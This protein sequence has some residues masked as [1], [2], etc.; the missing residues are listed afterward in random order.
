MIVTCEHCGARYKLDDS[1]I[2]GRGAKITCP[3][4]RHLF[5]V[6]RNANDATPDGKSAEASGASPAATSG[7]YPA[8]S[9]SYPAVPPRPSVPQ[10]PVADVPLD[11]HSLDFRRVGIPSWKV[12]VKIGLVYDFSDYRTLR[13]YIQDGRVTPGDHLSYD[14]ETWVPIASIPDLE[15]YFIDVYVKKQADFKPNGRE[16]GDDD[17]PTVIVGA[18]SLASSI[19]AHLGQGPM[20]APAAAG[21]PPSAG[22]T[23]AAFAASV[24]AGSSATVAGGFGGNDGGMQSQSRSGM[25]IPGLSSQ[26]G[27]NMDDGSETSGNF[28]D[29]F[30]ALKSKQRSRIK[31][32]R[33]ASRVKK[34]SRGGESS[35]STVDIKA[36]IAGVVLL[37]A[38]A[39]VAWEVWAFWLRPPVPISAE[40]WEAMQDPTNPLLVPP[41]GA[42]QPIV[43][44]ADQ[45]SDA[46]EKKLHDIY[47]TDRRTPISGANPEDEV[48]AVQPRNLPPPVPTNNGAASSTARPTTGS[49]FALAGKAAVDRGDWAVA[50]QSFNQAIKLEPSNAGHYAQLGIAQIR[51]GNTT[52][53]NATLAKAAKLGST[54][55]EREMGNI[56]RDR[57]DAAGAT[58][59]YTVYLRTDPPDRAEVQAEIDKLQGK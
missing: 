5:V 31:Q 29:P 50:I 4:C 52:E 16:A 43:P 7:S 59:H 30:E 34:K 19:S 20:P 26:S 9:G 10:T 57:G 25:S 28:S 47:T 41:G 8:T 23:A 22:S 1:K 21:G 51:A 3:R 39:V 36:A 49:E 45:G 12:K 6:Y 14:A 54:V 40:D 44:S 53:A 42:E 37:V 18:G 33:T 55:A 24:T 35:E 46:W 15:Q 27:L 11:V 13:K 48:R 56:A 2:T 32:N 17:G 58:Q 38:T